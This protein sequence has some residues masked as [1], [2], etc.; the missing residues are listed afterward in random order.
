M[1]MDLRKLNTLLFYLD[2]FF[3]VIGVLSLTT[4]FILPSLIIWF[5]VHISYLITLNLYKNK[6]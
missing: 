4:T 1:R 6:I 5:V 2:C 3:G